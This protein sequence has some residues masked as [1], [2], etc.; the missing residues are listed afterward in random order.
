VQHHSKCKTKPIHIP[1]HSQYN[2]I[3][4]CIHAMKISNPNKSCNLVVQ[5]TL[6]MTL[7]NSKCNKC[8]SHT[9]ISTILYTN[10]ECKRNTI[11]T[12]R[13]F[14]MQNYS[15]CK[16]TTI[17]I[18]YHSQCRT[19]TSECKTIPHARQCKTNTIHILTQV[20]SS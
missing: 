14:K 12:A 18:P 1:Y 13:P 15:K 20:L 10:K 16:T 5:G 7:Q 4:I 17:Y 9:Y 3:L 8:T 11:L 19:T 2:T 6:A